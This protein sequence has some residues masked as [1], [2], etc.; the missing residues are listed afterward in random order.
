MGDE[1]SRPRGVSR[2]TDRSTGEEISSSITDGIGIAIYTA[3]SA[4]PVVFRGFF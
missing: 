4:L 1:L 3:G 2:A